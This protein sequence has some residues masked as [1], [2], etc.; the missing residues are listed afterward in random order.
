[1]SIPK[2][3]LVVGPFSKAL[4]G[5]FPRALVG[6]FPWSPNGNQPQGRPRVARETSLRD[7]PDWQETSLSPFRDVPE[8]RETSL[9]D[10]PEWRESSISP[11]RDVPEWRETRLRDVPEWRETSLSPFRDV[12]GRRE[13]RL[14][15]LW[16]PGSCGPLPWA[17][18]GLF[19]VAPFPK[20]LGHFPR[21]LVDPPLALDL[22]I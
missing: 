10:V 20:A 21:A 8:W 13:E 11:F 6:P 22:Q 14:G 1:M 17:L 12:P 15:P 2:G 3:T 9:R 7:I 16:G 18:V 19:S 4:V 5:P